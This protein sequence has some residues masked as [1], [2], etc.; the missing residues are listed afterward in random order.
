MYDV[1]CMLMVNR[2]PLWYSTDYQVYMGT[3]MIVRLLEVC[4]CTCALINWLVLLQLASEQDSTLIATCVFKT[5]VFVF[6]KPVLATDI[7]RCLNLKF[8]SKVCQ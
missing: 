5:K 3:S 8:E 4:H 1:G 6:P 2:D 7:Y